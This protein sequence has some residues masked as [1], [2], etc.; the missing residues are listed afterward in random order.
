MNRDP[1][2]FWCQTKRH[3]RRFALFA[4]GVVI[5]AAL[6][7]G[8]ALLSGRTHVGGDLRYRYIGGVLILGSTAI[9]VATVRHWARW[10][11]AVCALAGAKAVFALLFG[12]T[13]SQPRLVTNRPLVFTILLQLAAIAALSYR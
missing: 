5:L 7:G 12:V 13:I 1:H 2:G 9:L 10:F 11:A 6:T 3:L 8:I 4:C